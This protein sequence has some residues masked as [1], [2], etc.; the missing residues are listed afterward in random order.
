M[1]LYM[2]KRN[3]YKIFLYNNEYNLKFIKLYFLKFII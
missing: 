2:E 3:K 1:K